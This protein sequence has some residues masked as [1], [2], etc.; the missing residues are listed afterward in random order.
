[1]ELFNE[2]FF[3][4]QEIYDSFFCLRKQSYDNWKFISFM[5]VSFSKEIKIVFVVRRSSMSSCGSSGYFSSSF[6]FSSSFF[7]FC[8]FKFVLKRFVI[9]EE[10]FI[11]GVLYVRK[12]F[13]IVG[14][15]VGWGFVV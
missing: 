12:I 1:M 10:F 4:F 7:V 15:V 9:F 14:D 2:K 11:F 13:M 3:F 6:I 5:L 8:N